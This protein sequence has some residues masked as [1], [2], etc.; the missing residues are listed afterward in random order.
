MEP[1]LAATTH[2]DGG[3]IAASIISFL[4][5]NVCTALRCTG[6]FTKAGS[7]G[8]PKWAA[9]IPIYHFIIMLR[10]AGGRGLGL[11][12]A[13]VPSRSI[14]LTGGGQLG[15]LIVSIIVINDISKSFGHGAG[16]TVGLVL[17]PSSSSG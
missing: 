1:L 16:F 7:Y 4:I 6:H 5:Y 8:Q 10:V 11:V 12:P 3:F 9:F 2:V 15:L 13:L 14:P 17:L